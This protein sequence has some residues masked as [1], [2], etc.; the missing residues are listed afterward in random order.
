MI[1]FSFI[2]IYKITELWKYFKYIFE[3][4]IEYILIDL[5]EM[6]PMKPSEFKI[7]CSV[8]SYD[9]KTAGNDRN[10]YV[11]EKCIVSKQSKA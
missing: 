2:G 6:F 5:N 3:F 8:E 4:E 9:E 11:V 10:Y 7:S 1:D